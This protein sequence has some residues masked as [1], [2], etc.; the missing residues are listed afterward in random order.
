[1]IHGARVILYG[2]TPTPPAAPFAMP[3][4]GEIGIYPPKHASPLAPPK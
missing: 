4:G 2:K 3:G 1:M